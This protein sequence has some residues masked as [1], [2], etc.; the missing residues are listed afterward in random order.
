MR[1]SRSVELRKVFNVI[2]LGAI[3]TL[4]VGIFTSCSNGDSNGTAANDKQSSGE[5]VKT[6]GIVQIIEHPSLNTIR[7]SFINQ[8]AEE[9]YRD[10]ENIK[11]DYQ[12]AQGDQTNLKTICQKFANNNYDLIV[13]I[14]T[15]SAQAAAGETKEIPVLFAACTDPVSAGL[16]AS[17]DKPGGNVTGTSDAVSAEQIM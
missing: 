3:L 14:A 1:R 15:P 10:G 8:L 13:A 17:L 5:S 12:N 11:I 16:V 6:I 9:G 7:E 2:L 4:F